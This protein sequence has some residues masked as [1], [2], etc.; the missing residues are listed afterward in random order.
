[1]IKLYRQVIYVHSKKILWITVERKL[2]FQNETTLTRL[3]K[4]KWKELILVW[5]DAKSNLPNQVFRCYIS[6]PRL[7]ALGK[8]I[9]EN[10]NHLYMNDEVKDT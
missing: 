9:H 7:K 4:M 3:L 5:A 1:M 6:T 10:L 8:I 2:G